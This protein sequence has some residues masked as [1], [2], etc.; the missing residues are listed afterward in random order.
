M[1]GMHMPHKSSGGMI[2]DSG[3]CCKEWTPIGAPMLHS[4]SG[5]LKSV[6]SRKSGRRIMCEGD[7]VGCAHGGNSFCNSAG[8]YTGEGMF[9]AGDL[10]A[11]L[12]MTG[13]R[14]SACAQRR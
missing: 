11:T 1:K 3:L 7:G 5:Y 9:A 4:A 8:V 13:S 2:S 14:H 10:I 12:V 6:S